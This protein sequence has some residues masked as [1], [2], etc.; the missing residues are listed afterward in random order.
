M[1]VQHETRGGSRA[2]TASRLSV[3]YIKQIFPKVSLR[4]WKLRHVGQ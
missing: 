2:G 1:S 4:N 3:F